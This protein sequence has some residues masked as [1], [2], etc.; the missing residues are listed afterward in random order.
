[1]AKVGD[2]SNLTVFLGS[3]EGRCGPFAFVASVQDVKA[4]ETVNF[5]TYHALIGLWDRKCASMVRPGVGFE[6]DVDRFGG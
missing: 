2:E 6:F 1:L 3:S 4:A 5:I